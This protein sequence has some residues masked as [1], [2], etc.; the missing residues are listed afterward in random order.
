M[1]DMINKET[2]MELGD[3]F[4]ELFRPVVFDKRA[5]NMRTDVKES[6]DAFEFDIDL[7]GFK[8]D[9]IDVTLKNGYLNVSAQKHT[10]KCKDETCANGEKTSEGESN[11]DKKPEKRFVR[12]ERFYSASRS[13][14]V[15]DKIKEED[16]KAKY[17]NGVLS[18]VVPKNKP[19]EIESHKIAID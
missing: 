17:E 11:A 19:K 16:I 2:E 15:G 12:K 10:E 14:Y 9:E 7:P 5:M 13:Y 6:D 3:L 8:K 1:R 18:L 4:D